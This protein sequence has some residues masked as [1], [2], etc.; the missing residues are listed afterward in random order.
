MRASIKGR[1]LVW[2]ISGRE[3][4]IKNRI[5]LKGSLP[6]IRRFFS[7]FIKMSSVKRKDKISDPLRTS[8]VNGVFFTLEKRPC[9]TIF[10]PRKKPLEVSVKL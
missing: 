8:F 3:F 6:S 9:S 5:S 2:E 10:N 1:D 4:T 7:C